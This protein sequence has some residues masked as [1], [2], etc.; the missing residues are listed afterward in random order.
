MELHPEDI[1]F[2]AAVGML[3]LLVVVLIV[4]RRSRTGRRADAPPAPTPEFGAVRPPSAAEAVSNVARNAPAAEPKPPQIQ[5]Q[6]RPA[7]ATYAAIAAAAAG[8]AGV[9]AAASMTRRKPVD[10][11]NALAG[12]RADAS[13]TAIAIAAHLGETPRVVEIQ[14]ARERSE[15]SYAAVAAGATDRQN[16]PAR[17]QPVRQHVC[18]R[19]EAVD[20]P[21]T[22]SYAAIAVAAAARAGAAT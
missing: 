5:P 4:A 10:Y 6:P 16:L 7:Q 18:Y 3:V 15:P 19:G 20:V 11:A 13:Y 17:S 21:P 1:G 22:A 2:I 9:P 12:M 14:Q 8:S